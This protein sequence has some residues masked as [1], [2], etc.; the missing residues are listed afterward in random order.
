MKKML[1][2]LAVVLVSVLDFQSQAQIVTQVGAGTTT[3]TTTAYPAP[4]GN[5][6]WGAR[7]QQLYTAAELTAAG[8]A[9]GAIIN[10]LGFKVVGAAQ[11]QQ[12]DNFEMKIAGVANTTLT[13]AWVAGTATVFGPVNYTPITGNNLLALSSPWIW[14][15]TDNLLVETCFNNGSFTN[16]ETIENTAIANMTNHYRADAAGVCANPAS[17]SVLG[18]R[19]NLLIN[20]IPPGSCL[21]PIGLSASN[22]MATSATLT[23]VDTL[24]S[25]PAMDYDIELLL[26]TAPPSGTPTTTGITTTTFNQTGLMPTTSYDYYVR[27]HCSATDT[28]VWFG[29]FTFTTP[30]SCVAPSALT[31]TNIT[32]SSVDLGWTENNASTDWEI[33][34]GA[35]GFTP[36]GMATF[37]GGPVTNPQPLGGLPPNT[38]FDYYVRTVCG[39]MDSS[40][41]T[42]PFTFCTTLGCD[43]VYNPTISGVTDTSAMFSWTD[44]NASAP[45]SWEIEIVPTGATPTGAGTTTTSSPFALNGLTTLTTYDVYIRTNCGGPLGSSPW[46][47][48]TTFTTQIAPMA[49]GA[50]T[51]QQDLF[52]EGFDMATASSVHVMNS[53]LA[54]DCWNTQSPPANFAAVTWQL[55]NNAGNSFATGPSGGGAAVNTNPG[56]VFLETS[57]TGSDTLYVP[58]FDLSN[59][60]DARVT[61][62]TH[63][64]GVDIDSVVLIVDD[65]ITE[66]QVWSLA[67]QQQTAG[68]DPWTLQNV[69]LAAYIGKTVTLKFLG[70]SD[71]CCSG[72][73]A[74]DEVRVQACVPT[75]PAPSALVS[76]AVTTTTATVAW[77]E[78]GSATS[79][80]VTVVPEGTD[81]NAA[82]ATNPAVTTNPL[83]LTGLMP[84]TSYDYY[85]RAICGTDKSAWGEFCP[86]ANFVTPPDCDSAR[87]VMISNITATSGMITW[88]D[89][90]M[91]VAPLWEIEIVA[92]PAAPTGAGVFTTTSPYM[93]TGLTPNTTYNVYIRAA[94][95]SMNNDYSPWSGPFPLITPCSVFAPP[96]CEDFNVGAPT[97]ACWTQADDGDATTGPLSIGTGAWVADN[98]NNV[99]GDPSPSIN[100]WLAQKRDWLI[101]PDY[102]LAVPGGPYQMEMEFDIVGFGGSTP[103]A[104]GSDDSVQV[105]IS[106]DAGATWTVL[107]TWDASTALTAPGGDLVVHD[108]SAYTGDT[109]RLAVWASEGAIDDLPDNEVHFDDFCVVPIPSCFEPYALTA[110]NIT[111]TTAELAWT[112]SNT[113]TNY[114]VELVLAGTTPTG[115]PTTPGAMNPFTVTGLLANTCYD[116][117]VRTNCSMTDSSLWA[118]PFTFCTPC[119]AISLAQ[120]NMDGQFQTANTLPTCWSNSA[121]HGDDWEMATAGIRVPFG[122]TVVDHT[123]GVANLY[124]WMDGSTPAAGTATLMSA[125]IANADITALTNPMFEFYVLSRN[126]QSHPTVA[127]ANLITAH[128]DL[129]AEVSYDNGTTWDTMA[130]HNGSFVDHDWHRFQIELDVTALGTNDLLVRFEGVESSTTSSNFY[131]DLAID[132]VRIFDSL[133]ANQFAADIATTSGNADC[134]CTDLN[135]WTHYGDEASS[136]LYIS[137]K[138]G[139]ISDP[140]L[141]STM[142][143]VEG[144]A[145]GASGNLGTLGVMAPYVSSQHWYLMN[146]FW[147]LDIADAARQPSAPSDVRFYYYDA[148]YTALQSTVAAAAYGSVITAH[149]D[150]IGYKIAN[151]KDPNPANNHATVLT[152]DYT[153]YAH[154][155]SSTSTWAHTADPVGAT[156]NQLEYQVTS[157]SGGGGGFGS[158]STNGPLPITLT[159]F[160][161]TKEGSISLAAWATENEEN[162]SHFNL[163]RSLDGNE[164]TTLGKVNSKAVNGTSSV[165]LKYNFMDKSPQIGHNYY[166]LEQVDQDGKMSYSD[167]IDLVWGADGSVVTIYPNPATD[168]LNVDVSIDKVAQIEVRLLDMSGRVVKSVVQQSA[169]GMNNVSIGLGDIATGV[170]GVQILENNNLIYSGKVNKTEK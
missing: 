78:N 58:T 77:T 70:N 126:E 8:L 166:R 47:G 74:L 5:Y 22:I 160:T 107:Q 129:F 7:H 37:L 59:A 123:A 155:A 132:D 112:D 144:A 127:D 26:A 10:E 11:N 115:V 114:D 157:F 104:L 108:L 44:S 137:V 170:Y 148:D 167:I 162:N 2:L 17:T 90:N 102:D 53:T 82:A 41:W 75:C 33:E 142:V 35:Q 18:N 61:F 125:P 29:P 122:V 54:G 120:F 92:A 83:P 161:V 80:D 14:N 81:P 60:T 138:K 85:V 87:S 164:F 51:S 30:A 136:E 111:Q 100:I 145:T 72:D 32:S 128:N 117:Y 147:D 67:G 143:H 98:F 121:T 49:C 34:I 86:V 152:A 103:S 39:P 42:G 116:Y 158:G 95:D 105:M 149:T 131:N 52:Y 25:M 153:G 19:P 6:W 56:Y 64:F 130:H 135:G 1:L 168:K 93:A 97:P 159:D 4:F 62:Y 88:A 109:V 151:D 23:W 150:L 16:N 154:G 43:S 20:Y 146:R 163:Q 40:L 13:T 46:T 84:A 57:G 55:D 31:A 69:S 15:G 119:G 71:G 140:L 96:V 169:K 141:N 94:C 113:S 106:N 73:M 48:P 134:E 124:A 79:W 101:S 110:T 12:L 139:T 66:T 68:T 9:P 3:N 27:G 165:E 99:A 65:G 38:C 91:P 89:S 24:N 36:T 118:G 76:S 63:F 45:A 50:G 156:T 28:S 21:P 133:C